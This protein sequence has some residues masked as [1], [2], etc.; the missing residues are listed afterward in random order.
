MGLG[1]LG[2]KAGNLGK[3][4]ENPRDSPGLAGGV[5]DALVMYIR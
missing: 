4:N 5:F 1:E 3:N 2:H